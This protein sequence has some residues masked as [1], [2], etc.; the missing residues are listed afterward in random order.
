MIGKQSSR[1][2][3]FRREPAKAS[4][5]AERLAS[6]L[7]PQ[8][9]S[10]SS[11]SCRNS[12][13]RP[14]LSGSC[15]VCERP[16]IAKCGHVRAHHWAHRGER[17]CDHWWEPRTD[18]H[19]NWQDKFPQPWQEFIFRAPSGEKHIADVHTNHGLT[20]EFQY[21]HL[22]PEER[23]GRESFYH[24]L[25][26][27]V[28]GSR[29]RRDLPRFLEG[30]QSCTSVWQQGVF[31]TPWPEEVF[32]RNWVG[33][34]VPVLFDFEGARGISEASMPLTE[35]L[36]C[37]LP[38]RV[39]NIAVI[40]PVSRKTF[41]QWAHEQPTLVPTQT[42]LADVAEAIEIS[43]R[44]TTLPRSRS[45]YLLQQARLQH[46]ASFSGRYRRRSRTF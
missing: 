7:G 13:R 44:L 32:P 8:P 39:D 2:A 4:H 14:G 1:D 3:D 5:K 36:W 35:P 30:R 15:P 23:A 45:L 12:S 9:G 46:L 37:L 20:I 25:V 24:N 18:W 22:R 28:S 41:V 17:V 26:W 21:S 42:I 10:S 29:L 40:F 33:C 16:L 27:V 6:G 43:R 11:T 34:T 38:G 31:T 19:Y